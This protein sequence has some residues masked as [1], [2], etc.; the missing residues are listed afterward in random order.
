MVWIWIPLP[1]G[2]HIGFAVGG[3][4]VVVVSV[5]GCRPEEAVPSVCSASS[6]RGREV[7]HTDLW[8]PPTGAST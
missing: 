4:E 7:F 1:H 2:T 8:V 3:V 6:A 5:P